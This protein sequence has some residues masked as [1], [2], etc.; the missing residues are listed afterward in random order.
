MERYQSQDK[1]DV[2]IE[3]WFVMKKLLEKKILDNLI[4]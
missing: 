4:L 3:F 2:I 1:K